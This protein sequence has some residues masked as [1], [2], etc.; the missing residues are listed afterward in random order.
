MKL[1]MRNWLI[2]SA[3]FVAAVAL[4]LQNEDLHQQNARLTA[5]RDGQIA[6]MSDLKASAQRLRSTCDDIAFENNA[7]LDYITGHSK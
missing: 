4:F 3:V 7:M 2:F 1:K 5:E 6:L